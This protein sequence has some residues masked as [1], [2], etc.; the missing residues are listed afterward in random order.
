MKKFLAPAI[1]ATLFDACPA[2][3]GVPEAMQQNSGKWIEV[4]KTWII[5]TEDVERRGDQLRFWVER[6]AQGSEE[7]S[8][9]TRT[10]WTGKYRIRCSDFHS[11]IDGGAINGYGMR[12]YVPGPWERI[13]PGDFGYTLASNFCYLTG[14]PGY[15][16][17]PINYEWQR[18]IT[19]ALGNSGLQP[20]SI[21][22]NS[23]SCK[24]LKVDFEP[25]CW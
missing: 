17:E 3:S 19:A 1:A 6:R 13:K 7:S 16:P 5:D 9:Q 4:D 25:R 24:G 14:T 12:I 2:I 18:K 21:K 22:E 11:R 23:L 15:T 10:S 8:T 20:K